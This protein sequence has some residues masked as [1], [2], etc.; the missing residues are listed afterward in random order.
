MNSGRRNWL[1]I[2][3]PIA[4]WAATAMAV[5]DGVSESDY[6]AELPVVLSVSRL[7]QPLD[8]AP[9]AVTVID[10]EMIRLSGARHVT[11]LLRFVPG[12]QISDSFDALAPLVSYH[13]GFN[14]FPNQMQVLIDGRSVYASYA[15]GSVAPGLQSIDLDDIER[16]EVLRGSNSAAYGA[17]AFLGVVNIITR[18]PIETHGA[19]IIKRNGESRINDEFA[20]VGWGNDNA[21]FRLSAGERQDSALIGSA[22]GDKVSNVNLRGDFI[23]S[24]RDEINLRAGSSDQD[25]R[26]GLVGAAENAPREREAALSFVQADWHHSFAADSDLQVSFSHGEER[27]KDNFVLVAPGVCSLANTLLGHPEYC[28]NG[29]RIDSGG[30]ASNDNIGVQHTFRFGDFSRLVWG[31]ELRS[32][33]VQAAQPYG[34][35][36]TFTTQFRRVFGNVELRPTPSVLANIGGMIES[37]SLSGTAF[38]PRVML[39]WHF[40]PDHTLRIGASKAYRPPSTYEDKVNTYYVGTPFATPTL[41]TPVITQTISSGNL[42]P[43][44]LTA[45][46][47]GY[48]GEFRRIGLSVDVR[49]F[50]ESL[51]NYIGRQDAIVPPL[52]L[53]KYSLSKTA[54]SY[55]NLAGFPIRGI[56]GQLNYRPWNGTRILFNHSSI[57]IDSSN[58]SIST[59]APRE[60]DGLTL[61]QQLPAGMDLSIMHMQ[62]SSAPWI[63]SDNANVRGPAWRRL[64][65]RISKSLKVG[66]TNGELAAVVQNMGSPYYDYRTSMKVNTT[67]GA[68]TIGSPAQF[69]RRA[70]LT[71]SL[72]M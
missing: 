65:M 37:S 39:N 60:S 59:A 52:A 23:V 8:E 28:F 63:S 12:F 13:G 43:E 15:I 41:V 40:V 18:D 56:E 68:V 4:T 62:A 20:R 22:G 72:E 14:G 38:A 2:G 53:P 25:Q 31:I 44:S 5:P 34:T 64:D 27:Y 3:L 24:A 66:A 58:P 11:E 67:T 71:L 6:F 32:E 50:Y 70:F 47:I 54:D 1:A 26:A 57:R 16:I 42:R 19:K 7:A 69:E 45:S 48:L 36:T 61:F 33:S 46:E 17:R 21:H 10:R 30:R 51:G 29:I 35:D 9:G 49:A 55:G